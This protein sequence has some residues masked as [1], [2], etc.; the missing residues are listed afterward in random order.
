MLLGLVGVDL[1]LVLL[2]QLVVLV[3]PLGGLGLLIDLEVKVKNH[4]FWHEKRAENGNKKR[5]AGY[6]IN[7]GRVYLQESLGQCPSW[8]T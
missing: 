7:K 5:Y 6:L 8:R 4:A 3:L 2:D 1:F